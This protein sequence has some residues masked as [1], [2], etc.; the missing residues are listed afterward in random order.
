M[1]KYISQPQV[2][3]LLHL[4]IFVFL[5]AGVYGQQNKKPIQNCSTK[6]PFFI[7]KY[8]QAQ[9]N[10]I[11]RTIDYL[12]VIRVYVHILRNN[13]GT[14]AATTETQM[15]ADLQTMTNF[16]KPH[17]ICFIFVGFDV[18]NTFLNNSMNP[19]LAADEAALLANNKHN[20]AIDIYV[21]TSLG[22]GSGGNSYNIPSDHFSV[23][24]S[25]PFNFYHEMGHCLGLLH[26]FETAGGT[27]CPDG[28]NCN[29]SGDLIC[30][31]QADFSGS[32]NMVTAPNSCIYTGNQIIVCNGNTRSY[33]PPII[34]IMSYWSACYA[35]FTVQQATRMRTT[36]MNENIVNKCLIPVN[37][38]LFANFSSITIL[39]EWYLAS[40][41]E[42]NIGTLIPG[43]TVLIGG[44]NGKKYINAGTKISLKPGTIIRPTG[45]ATKFLINKMCD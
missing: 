26:T 12:Y 20:D 16:F 14:N 45:A 40:K 33:T 28:S 31:T 22:D 11:E 13:D 35:Q 1:K 9:M 27:E 37:A 43:N 42:I 18:N 39:N 24:Q 29:S 41:N 8:T 19:G 5:Y 32:E 4:L 2:F 25:T 23:L 21:H 44:G 3:F 10:S 38:D 36:I 6:T 7:K 34:N 15:Y 17:N 30:D